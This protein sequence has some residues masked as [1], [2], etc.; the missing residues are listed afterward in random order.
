V[1]KIPPVAFAHVGLNVRDIDRMER[2]YAGFLGL[3]V[4]DRGDLGDAR[5]V[6]LSRDAR[7]HHQVVLVAG[8]NPSAGVT[9]LNQV[10][11]RVAD[12]AALRH[13][14]AHAAGHGAS[15]AE[16]VTHG[17]AISLYLRDPEGNRIEFYIDTPWYVSQPTR[18]PVDLAEPDEAVWK[19]VEAY[20]R[21]L[22]GFAP[23][24]DWRRKLESRL[25]AS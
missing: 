23:V 14:Q 2:F 13:F 16:A 25:A 15:D 10:S 4:T 9:V 12:L 20:A 18:A 11:L 21:S 19:S 6:F 24:E 17:N 1:S 5:L 22:P 7:E 8:Q 3:V